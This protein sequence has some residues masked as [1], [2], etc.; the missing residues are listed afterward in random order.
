MGAGRA[1]GNG[2]F[3]FEDQSRPSL[4]DRMTQQAFNI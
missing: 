2:A 1:A 3:G 4:Q